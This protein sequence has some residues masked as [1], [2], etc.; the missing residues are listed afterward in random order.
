MLNNGI[1]IHL[2]IWMHCVQI[3][4]GLKKPTIFLQGRTW[5]HTSFIEAVKMYAL[6][7]GEPAPLTHPSSV[8]EDTEKV[9][10]RSLAPGTEI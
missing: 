10:L 6:G 5:E 8:S 1:K 3:L 9:T 7:V 4:N 2:E